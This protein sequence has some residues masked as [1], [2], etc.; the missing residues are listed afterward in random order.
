MA[1]SN[2]TIHERMVNSLEA[3][4][5]VDLSSH[6]RT[7]LIV[8]A[9]PQLRFTSL[10]QRPASLVHVVRRIPSDTIPGDGAYETRPRP[11]DLL[12]R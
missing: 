7:I 10:S 9:P 11:G 3:S 5:I 1:Y 6:E 2:T 8:S 12:Q 4:E